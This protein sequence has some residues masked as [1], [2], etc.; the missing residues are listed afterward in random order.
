MAHYAQLGE[1]NI[2]TRVVKVN[3]RDCMT[4]GGIEK[5]DLGAQY[6]I[7]ITGHLVW[8]KCSYNTK[9]GVHQLGGT[10]LRGNYPTIGWYY[11]STHD[12][13]HQSR[14]TDQDGNACTTWTLNTTTGAWD[15]P[16]PK[17]TNI[18]TVI[19]NEATYAGVSTTGW[20]G[21]TTAGMY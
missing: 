12:I 16:V 11:N 17:P 6:L 19:W 7:G 9:Y 3:N 13:F 1:D 15:P 10:A 18:S 21:I 5:E 2:V 20:V 4:E 8:K 14:P